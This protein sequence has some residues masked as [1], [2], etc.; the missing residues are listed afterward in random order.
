M[1]SVTRICILGGGFGGLYTALRA[2]QLAWEPG[3]KPEITLIDRHP[4]FVFTPLL[5]E[6]ITGEM[7]GW[8]IAPPFAE[9]LKGTD[10][11]FVQGSVKQI[12]SEQKTVRLEDDT[13]IAYDRLV[14][15]LGSETPADSVPGVAEHAIA[16]RSLEDAYKLDTKLRLLEASNAE[17]IRVAIVGAGYT[18]VEIACKLAD[19]LKERGRIRL[20]QSRDTILPNALEFNRNAALK[21]LERRGI[22]VDLETNVS[23]ITA[24]TIGLIYKGV[25]DTIPVEIVMWTVGNQ[26]SPAIDR[27]GLP[28]NAEG[29]LTVTETL[30][31]TENPDI[32]ALGDAA[33]I[34]AP[35]G[36]A[37]P[38]NAQ[39]AFQQSDFVAWNVWSSLTNRPLLPFHYTN[40]G[41]MLTLGDDNAALSSMGIQLDGPLAYLARRLVYLYRLPTIE[42]QL[43]VGLNWLTQPLVKMLS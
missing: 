23:E 27:F 30:Q 7:Q 4:N 1:T 34:L 37:I 35:H 6:L 40:L 10:I 33:A 13:E 24:D 3:Q 15:S 41:E 20:I 12:D 14:L 2:N 11:R 43:K 32:F 19:R 31:V 18:G 9:L 25:T 42:H 5:Y 29:K 22:W 26:V 16:F 8:E 28:A 39:V 38:T 17:R 36:V 21:A